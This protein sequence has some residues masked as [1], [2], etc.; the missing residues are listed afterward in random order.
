MRWL[1]KPVSTEQGT[2]VLLPAYLQVAKDVGA[3]TAQCLP[4]PQKIS[5]HYAFIKTRL[6]GL[7]F[8]KIVPVAPADI[9]Q[10]AI[11]SRAFRARQ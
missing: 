3:T 6:G 5:I 11:K 2:R 1:G 4:A 8:E 10:A 7:F 9:A